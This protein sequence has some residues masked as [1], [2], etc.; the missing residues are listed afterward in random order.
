LHESCSTPK[1]LQLEIEHWYGGEKR[2]VEVYS[3]TALGY[4]TGHVPVALRWVLIRDPLGAVDPQAWL[5]TKRDHTPWQILTFFVRRWRMEVTFEEARAHLGIETQRQWHD[6]AIARPTPA[7][8]GLFSLVTLLATELIQGQTQFVRT[9]A[10]YAKEQPTFVD[11][12]ALVRRC[13]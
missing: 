13:L 5:S 3:E 10:W 9:A 4:K 8:F 1:W 7:L 12:L 2:M 11:A 6:L